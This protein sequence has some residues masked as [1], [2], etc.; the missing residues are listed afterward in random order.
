MMFGKK[1]PAAVPQVPEYT[2]QE[3]DFR[4]KNDTAGVNIDSNFASQS[5]WKDVYKRFISNKGALVA[6]VLIVII[7]FFAIVGPGMNQYGYADQNLAEKNFDRALC[8]RSWDCRGHAL[9]ASEL[10]Y[11]YEVWTEVLDLYFR[12]ASGDLP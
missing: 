8:Q 3:D 12:G 9:C 6:L 7:T 5:Y 4:L 1:K 10:L 11:R 2:F